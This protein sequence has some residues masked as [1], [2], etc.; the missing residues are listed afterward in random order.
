MIA[1]P[2]LA[3]LVTSLL[4]ACLAI[5]LSA[6]WQQ[7]YC[8]RSL[9]T[10]F[11]RSWQHP[12]RFS[13]NIIVARVP[14]N[15]N[16]GSR[17]LPH[18]Y[19]SAADRSATARFYMLT[20]NRLWPR[21]VHDVVDYLTAW[22]SSGAGRSA[23]G[24]AAQAQTFTEKARVCQF[25]TRF[26]NMRW[27]KQPTMNCWRPWRPGKHGRRGR[28]VKS[29]FTSLSRLRSSWSMM[30]CRSTGGDVRGAALCG[31]GPV[32]GSLTT[33]VCFLRPCGWWAVRWVGPW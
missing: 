23:I 7:H 1:M 33:V 6:V 11:S 27:S 16:S 30:A 28:L 4:P 29:H 8:S 32:L 31:Y 2:R 5:L 24:R 10:S 19:P 21:S 22:A 3:I 17:P 15:D 25:R 20:F 12:S 14:G 9:A 18:D 26:R 13:G